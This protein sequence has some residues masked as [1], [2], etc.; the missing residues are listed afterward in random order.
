MSDW[1]RSVAIKPDGAV[2]VGTRQNLI[3]GLR[4]KP[5]SA[6][7]V[8]AA[9]TQATNFAEKL[10]EKYSRAV[11]PGEVGPEGIA[12]AGVEP[13][14]ANR[15]PTISIRSF[16]VPLGAAFG[17][18]FGEAELKPKFDARMCRMVSCLPDNAIGK[19]RLDICFADVQEF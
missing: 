14:L 19:E 11:A 8:D 13:I 6:A 15:P 9:L 17:I 12:R 3:D 18:A 5:M 7:A 10:V 16:D 4:G 1:G 2:I